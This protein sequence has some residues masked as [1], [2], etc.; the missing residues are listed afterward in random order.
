MIRGTYK[1]NAK[2]QTMTQN[3]F[4]S[5]F[6]FFLPTLALAFL[7][8][9]SLARG[10]STA[11]TIEYEGT[12]NEH[13][14]T[15]SMSSLDQAENPFQDRF[16]EVR[17]TAIKI[18]HAAS[19]LGLLESNPDDPAL[20]Y[21][22]G[23][24]IQIM[25]EFGTGETIYG[26]YTVMELQSYMP[27]LTTERNRLQEALRSLPL[28][29]RMEGSVLLSSLFT[30]REAAQPKGP[31]T[32]HWIAGLEMEIAVL[33]NLI[34]HGDCLEGSTFTALPPKKKGIFGR[35]GKVMH[36]GRARLRQ[37]FQPSVPGIGHHS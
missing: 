28:S 8:L 5:P 16:D 13:N 24:F 23:P 25:K 20:P 33:K 3:L 19:F 22:I 31:S 35:I 27:A 14:T 30:D 21:A 26:N 10:S 34:A 36:T 29:E 17:E 4:T 32:Q 11:C 2:Q 12:D 15:C 7:S 18:P 37:F 1:N 6:K 9:P